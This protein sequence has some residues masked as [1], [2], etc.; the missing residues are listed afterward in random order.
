[1][2]GAQDHNIRIYY[3]GSAGGGAQWLFR[4]IGDKSSEFVPDCN[5]VRKDGSYIYEDF[6][7]TEGTD[8]KVMRTDVVI[9]IFAIE[10]TKS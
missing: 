10:S 4:K 9:T 6:M 5:E 2:G 7:A 1:L 8:V 3:P